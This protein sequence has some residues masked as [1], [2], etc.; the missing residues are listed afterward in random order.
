MVAGDPQSEQIPI[1]LL[2][3]PSSLLTLIAWVGRA[4]LHPNAQM[5]IRPSRDVTV[6]TEGNCVFCDI[7]AGDAAAAI[8]Y[9][10]ETHLAFMD[11]APVNPGH[12]LLLPKDHY[13]TLL[14]MPLK[15]VGPLF[16]RAA[17]I[18][19]AVGD[20]L[21]ADGINVGQ[22]N[23][24]AANQ[25]VFH[26]HVHIIPRYER[27]SPVGKW[28]TRQVAALKDL[29]QMAGKIRAHVGPVPTS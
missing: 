9:E 14:D 13:P 24:R 25:I 5:Q 29:E 23:G 1:M 20:A 28:P 7:V 8:V 16:T 6:K 10:D 18:A 27:D 15:E 2:N 22:N 26:V 3:G 11:K 4:E 21:G 12:V 19:A 17:H